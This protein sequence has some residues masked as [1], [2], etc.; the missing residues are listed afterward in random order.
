M[1][2]VNPKGAQCVHLS[3]V[4]RKR[5]KTLSQHVFHPECMIKKQFELYLHHMTCYALIIDHPFLR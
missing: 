1:V 2:K 3:T 4:R 5:I